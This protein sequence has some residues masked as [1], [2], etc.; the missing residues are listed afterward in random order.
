MCS[1]SRTRPEMGLTETGAG[2]VDL[3]SPVLLAS[4]TLGYQFNFDDPV[5]PVEFAATNTAPFQYVRFNALSALPQPAP[6]TFGV[7]L[8]EFRAFTVPEPGSIVLAAAGIGA[9]MLRVRRR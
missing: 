8:N 5:E 9:L 6:M 7:G 4:G 1:S 3:V 2:G